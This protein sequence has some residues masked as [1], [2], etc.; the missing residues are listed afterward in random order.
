MGRRPAQTATGPPAA[1]GEREGA[2]LRS[3][4]HLRWALMVHALATGILAVAVVVAPVA[5]H[6][7]MLT[8][9][10]VM[11]AETVSSA[12]GRGFVEP[13]LHRG[14]VAGE[15]ADLA[16]LDD[17]VHHRVLSGPLVRVKLWRPDGTIV[18]SDERRLIGCR[19]PLDEDRRHQF[20]D[21]RVEAAVT[22][23]VSAEHRYEH[24]ARLLEVYTPVHADDGTPLLMET[25]FRYGGVTDDGPGLGGLVAAVGGVWFL[26]LLAVEVPFAALVRRRLRRLDR[27]HAEQVGWAVEAERRRIAQSLHDGVVQDLTGVSLQL[28]AVGPDRPPGDAQV[29]SAAEAVR[30]SIRSLRSLLVDLYPGSPGTKRLDLAIGGLLGGMSNR[31]IATHLVV[32]VDCQR[33]APVL[34]NALYRAAQ[35]AL[36][37]V[38]THAGA[39]T[40]RVSL[41]ARDGDVVLVVEDDGRGF[42]AASWD[43]PTEDGHL[44]LAL[45]RDVLGRVGGR[46]NV[47]SFP[48]EGTRFTARVRW[49]AVDP[50]DPSGTDDG[51]RRQAGTDGTP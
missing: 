4:L 28:A 2:W 32:G 6:R 20:G 30:G 35:E 22:E 49:I 9:R 24:D 40:V 39:T 51:P 19:F 25:Y 34:A 17:E 26:F 44:G 8:D 50:D 1:G 37:N 21:G 18:Y 41:T 5:V 16:R 42:W 46:L 36:R 47:R 31:G 48:G 45:T 13:L 14:V 10:A 33:L 11:D 3:R 27:D 38:V 7:R 15:G 29:R 43:Q 23:M 12:T